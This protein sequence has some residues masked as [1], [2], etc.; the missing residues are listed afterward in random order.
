MLY[1]RHK[2]RGESPYS[3]VVWAAQ[4][5]QQQPYCFTISIVLLSNGH[6]VCILINGHP[7]LPPLH[8]PH[9]LTTAA[10]SCL[11]CRALCEVE[12]GTLVARKS[13]VSH[14]HSSRGLQW[15]LVGLGSIN[16]MDSTK[17][18]TLSGMVQWNPFEINRFFNFSLSTRRMHCICGIKWQINSSH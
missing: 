15:T 11:N 13:H 8:P 9:Q 5:E 17:G 12:V 1:F 18:N 6:L 3:A 14:S 4:E 10:S 2:G 16:T 7:C